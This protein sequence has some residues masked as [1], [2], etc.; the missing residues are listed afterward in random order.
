MSIRIAI[1]GFG[2]MGRNIFRAVYGRDDIQVVAIN[3]IAAPAAMEYLLRFDSL[4][5]RFSDPV[6]IAHA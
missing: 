4:H 1:M 3:D 5:G 2:R 6:R